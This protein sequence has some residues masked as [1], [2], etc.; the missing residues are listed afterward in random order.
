MKNNAT[1]LNILILSILTSF[2]FLSCSKDDQKQETD[3]SLLIGIWD[4]RLI[5]SYYKHDGEER[6]DYNE[7][8]GFE[9]LKFDGKNYGM[10]G[11]TIQTNGAIKI[12]YS[13]DT[14]KQTITLSDGTKMNVLK[15]TESELEIESLY[16]NENVYSLVRTTYERRA[17]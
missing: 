17:E 6:T 7:Y 16:E 13:Y 4:S 15:L 1:F 9:S 12:P 10:W 14:E 3:T 8:P 2:I 11:P 5:Y